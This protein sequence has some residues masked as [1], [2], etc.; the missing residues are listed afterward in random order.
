MAQII[1]YETFL[2]FEHYNGHPY[3][4]HVPHAFIVQGR[5]QYD[6]LMEGGNLT[7]Q[8][9]GITNIKTCISIPPGLASLA[10]ESPASLD[11][12]QLSEEHR[13]AVREQRASNNQLLQVLSG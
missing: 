2:Y 11:P 9:I 4:R 3:R 8:Q 1:A 13:P 10:A 12:V 7:K 6:L 5:A